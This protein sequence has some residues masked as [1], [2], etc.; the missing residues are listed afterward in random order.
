MSTV[1]RYTLAFLLP[2]FLSFAE[3]EAPWVVDHPNSS[4]NFT[5]NHMMISQIHGRFHEF[6]ASVHLNKDN[7]EETKLRLTVNLKSIDT[8]LEQRDS[9][10]RSKDFLDVENYTKLVF[11]SK[12]VRHISGQLYTIKGD[13]TIK[14]VT[15]EVDLKLV[16]GG[17]VKDYWGNER[18][19]LKILG[20]FNRFDFGLNWNE[21][22]EAGGLIVGE[23]VNIM[24]TIEAFQQQGAFDLATERE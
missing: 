21:L 11:A 8:G 6:F 19:G 2:A 7:F 9:H 17:M 12:S 13:L 15:H 14:D 16:H 3:A 22:L 24:A 5:I 23:E 10:L 18:A 4:V 20:S 1:L